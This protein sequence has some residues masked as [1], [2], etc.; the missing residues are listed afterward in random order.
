MLRSK[1]WFGLASLLGITVLVGLGS[2]PGLAQALSASATPVTPYAACQGAPNSQLG[3]G[4]W[5]VVNPALKVSIN[6]R[7]KPAQ[8]AASLGL[9]APGAWAKVLAG[10]ECADG[11]AWWKVQSA[12]TSLIGWVA[13]GDAAG[14]AL[15]PPPPPTATGTP[16]PS[17]TPTPTPNYTATRQ[18]IAAA[19]TATVAAGRAVA[20]GAR[21]TATALR[22]TAMVQQTATAGAMKAY[23]TQAAKSAGATLQA[24]NAAQTASAQVAPTRTA[25][26]HLTATAAR[27][28]YVRQLTAQVQL[29]RDTGTQWAAEAT[30]KYSAQQT[31]V[32]EATSAQATLDA[33]YRYVTYYTS[34]SDGGKIRFRAYVASISGQEVH[35]YTSTPDR[36]VVVE[37]AKGIDTSDLH[38]S[39]TVAYTFYGESAR[40]LKN[41]CDGY[42]CRNVPYLTHALWLP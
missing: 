35:V 16:K 26:A 6:L 7:A 31:A 24:F 32:A 23:T 11:Y 17:R 33:G 21:Q 10:P 14:Y 38:I 20:T 5:S 8:A 19:S 13:E 18:A 30:A 40:E 4:T 12:K 15:M 41:I 27:A 28:D 37:L 9:M 2:T 29:T 42:G 25:Q 39:P 34:L 36:V 3:V 22:Q 1:V